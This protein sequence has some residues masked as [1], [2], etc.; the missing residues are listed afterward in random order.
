[1]S[2]NIIEPIDSFIQAGFQKQLEKHFSCSCVYTTA[3]DKTRTLS[4]IIKDNP[5]YPYIFIV[6][7]NLS[8][9]LDSYPSAVLSR[10]GIPVRV[11]TSQNQALTVTVLPTKFDLELT[12]ISNKH[13][14]LDTKSVM[15]FAR[16]WLMLRRLGQLSFN[17]NFGMQVLPVHCILG[18]DVPI[19]PRENATDGES[20]YQVVVTASIN[21]YISEA[22]TDTIGVVSQI[23][24][25]QEIK[26]LMPNSK[27][28]PFS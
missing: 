12:Y 10:E 15:G 11:S 5:V 18:Q 25:V 7:Q 23:D 17:V 19:Q 28:T 3:S 27:F 8:Q 24:V 4:Q 21:G 13:N 9:N 26:S 16:K 6:I 2:I 20:V 1:M 14:G 22:Q